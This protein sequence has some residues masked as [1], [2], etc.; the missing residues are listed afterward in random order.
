MPNAM[1]LDS[2]WA[3]EVNGDARS[4]DSLTASR[5]DT[6]EIGDS[7]AWL[8]RVIMLDATDYCVNYVLQFDSIPT[9]TVVY[10]NGERVNLDPV[11]PYGCDITA[12]VALGE[13]ELAFWVD[14]ES[15][16]SFAGVRLQP[17]PCD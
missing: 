14:H 13:N 3:C 9:G 5:L 11:E 12:Y 7:G 15:T 8:R 2:N 1:L 17:V 16:G 10:V 4:I 6:W